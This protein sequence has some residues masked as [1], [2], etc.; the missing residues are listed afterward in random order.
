MSV[1]CVYVCVCVWRRR[2][3][4]TPIFLPG[5]SH[6]QRNLVGYSSGG[7]T[8]VR[9]D[10]GLYNNYV[11]MCMWGLPRWFCGKEPAC[12]CWRCK[13]LEFDPWV[14]KIP[15]RRAWQPTPLFLSVKSRGQ[16]SPVAC[17]SWDHRVRHEWA[18]GHTAHTHVHTHKYIYIYVYIL[19]L[20][21]IQCSF[22]NNIPFASP[23]W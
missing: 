22:I 3:Q 21:L 10:L 19:Y 8:R 18:T 20:M 5:K 4:P 17:S 2:W 23:P 9:H 11:Y 12:Q 7:C 6:E 13:R 15:W 1:V 16:R 14:G